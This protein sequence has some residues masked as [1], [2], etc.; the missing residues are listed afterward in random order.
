[1]VAE[2]GQVSFDPFSQG[3]LEGEVDVDNIFVHD[4]VAH[5][6]FV[7]AR[8]RALFLIFGSHVASLPGLRL[9]EFNHGTTEGSARTR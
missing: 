3:S 2:A 1:M 9:G 4:R 6:V 8:R 5:E 7:A